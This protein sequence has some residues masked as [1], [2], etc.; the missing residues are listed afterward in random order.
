MNVRIVCANPV[1]P[2]CQRYLRGEGMMTVAP[3][4]IL[5]IVVAGGL[6]VAACVPPTPKAGP[7]MVP[8]I[9]ETEPLRLVPGQ[10]VL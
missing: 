3:T 4:I 9:I 5:M 8:Q 6:S 7:P 1:Q 2:F 10:R